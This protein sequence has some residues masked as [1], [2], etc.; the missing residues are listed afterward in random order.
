MFHSAFKPKYRVAGW[1]L[2]E[3]LVATSVVVVAV[4]GL[5]Q[6]VAGAVYANTRA[7]AMTISVV[8]A[9]QKM[10]EL[11]AVFA[12]QD[13]HGAS[14]A[15][16]PAG[17]LD[18]DTAG[19]SDY[20]VQNGAIYLRRWS[21]DPLPAFPDST[22]VLNVVA[23]RSRGPDDAASEVTGRPDTARVITVRTRRSS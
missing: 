8:L 12:A 4:S 23:T 22:F 16:S 18:R 1:S 10:E 19:Y 15:A 17:A 2:I 5:A 9:E 7:K 13:A 6:L 21:I 14:P 11:V 20:V 3:V